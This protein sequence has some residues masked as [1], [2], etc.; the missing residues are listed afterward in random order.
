[1]FTLKLLSAN[2]TTNIISYT[3]V[4]WNNYEFCLRQ[5]DHLKDYS[6][7]IILGT[8]IFCRGRFLKFVQVGNR[9]VSKYVI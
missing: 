1:M 5:N 4:T 7:L 8:L 2:Q 9:F 3:H 6:R